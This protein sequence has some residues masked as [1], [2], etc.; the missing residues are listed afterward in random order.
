MALP[1]YKDRRLSFRHKI[2]LTVDLVMEDGTILP[3]TL[4]NISES[5]AQFRCDSW[6][7]NE[8]EP[9]GVQNH[10]CDNL[11]LK[12]VA[13]LNEQNKLYSLCRII[14]AQRLSQDS[15]EIGLEF[16]DFEYGSDQALKQ[17]LD[18]LD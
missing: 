5:G 13:E 18:T 14:S 17:Y 12:L 15:Y 11:Q 10:L 9:R 7:A 1:G 8:I 3:A 6:I 16:I 2:Y 4:Q